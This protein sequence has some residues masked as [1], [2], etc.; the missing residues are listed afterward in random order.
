V[1]LARC[2]HCPH[3]PDGTVE[4]YARACACRKPQP[5]LL[6]RAARD[7][8]L[9]LARS[10]LVGDILD[11]VEAGRRAGC[12]TVLLDNGHETE[13]VLTPERLP[14]HIACDLA[15]AADLILSR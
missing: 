12:R 10:W 9:D 1:P 14:H 2:Y 15:Q 13:W 5:G 8:D 7:H 3:H 6:L 4:R 11:D